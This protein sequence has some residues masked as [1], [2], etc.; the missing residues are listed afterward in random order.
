MTISLMRWW[1]RTVAGNSFRPIMVLENMT[2]A[3]TTRLSR[4][5]NPTATRRRT[6]APHSGPSSPPSLWAATPNM[7]SSFWWMQVQ[8]EQEQQEDDADVGHVL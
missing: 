7:C 8:A 2:A 3:P 6:R 1:V 4:K 5:P